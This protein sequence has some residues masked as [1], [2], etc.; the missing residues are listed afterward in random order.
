MQPAVSRAARGARLAG[1][2]AMGVLAALPQGCRREAA[3]G[4]RSLSARRGSAAAAPKHG[5]ERGGKGTSQQRSGQRARIE[6]GEI[7]VAEPQ[8]K[9]LWKASAKVIEWDYDRQLA[10]LRDVQCV[11]IDNDKPALE[12]RAPVVTAYLKLR[13][14]VLTGGVSARSVGTHTSLRADRL[15]WNVKDKEV[16]AVGNVKY[17]RGD[18]VITGSRLRADLALKR[19]RLEGA[20]QMRAVEPFQSK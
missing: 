4:A 17:V 12:A 2:I 20:V 6:M 15:E 10:A 18:F 7:I 5:P 11:F 13:R 3:P 9:R 1:V 8:G 14:V 16:Y 19:A